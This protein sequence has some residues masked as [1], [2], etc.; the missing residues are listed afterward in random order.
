MK[1]S[2]TY[3]VFFFTFSVYRSIALYHKHSSY[4]RVSILLE[5]EFTYEIFNN[6]LK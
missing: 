6:L 3:D 4:Y 5:S 1:I 2:H